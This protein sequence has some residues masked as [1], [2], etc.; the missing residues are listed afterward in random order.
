MTQTLESKSKAPPLAAEPNKHWG[1][2]ISAT[3]RQPL[4]YQSQPPLSHCTL[5][6]WQVF[7]WAAA[8]VIWKV[9]NLHVTWLDWSFRHPQ[10]CYDLWTPTLA[11]RLV[12]IPGTDS[13]IG[14]WNERN[15]AYASWCFIE[16]L[17]HQ[18]A[19]AWRTWVGENMMEAVGRE[20]GREVSSNRLWIWMNPEKFNLGPLSLEIWE[21]NWDCLSVFWGLLSP[22]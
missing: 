9:N 2:A 15:W 1:Q 19:E 21:G 16:V 11:M 3:P 18:R 20:R 14:N 8:T 4:Q 7:S 22:G 10:A 13:H 17:C 5:Q 6:A 12:K